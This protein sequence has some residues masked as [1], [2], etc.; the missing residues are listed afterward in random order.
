ML[1]ESKPLVDWIKSQ[2]DMNEISPFLNI[3]VRYLLREI[4]K[5]TNESIREITN[6]D[7]RPGGAG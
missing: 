3:P 2:C 1:I 4:D 7:D 6:L 5:L